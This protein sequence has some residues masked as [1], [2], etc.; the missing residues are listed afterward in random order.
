MRE[1]G[2]HFLRVAAS[3][4]RGSRDS[5]YRLA[6]G[7]FPFV[8]RAL[9]AGLRRG[10]VTEITLHGYNL[11]GVNRVVLGGV[12]AEARPASTSDGSLRVSLAVPAV[13]TPRQYPLRVFSNGLEAPVPLPLLVS[14]LD[15]RLAIPA[16]SRAAPQSVQA[17][18][19]V[20]GL[21]DRRRASHFFALDVQAGDRYAFAVDAMKLGYLVDPFL[22]PVKPARLRVLVEP[23]DGGDSPL[24]IEPDAPLEGVQWI[25]NVIPAGARQI[26]IRLTATQPLRARTFRLRASLGA[27]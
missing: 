11:S 23:F 14:D 22:T 18:V 13:V 5:S 8:L 15:E 3:G 26:E 17:P 1:S 20:T 19:A 4:E 10:A 9:P 25:N 7:S 16:V 21:L 6:A 12:F 24:V 2:D 27:H